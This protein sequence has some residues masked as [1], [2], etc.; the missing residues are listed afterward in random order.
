[1][2]SFFG[3]GG[4]IFTCRRYFRLCSEV[5]ILVNYCALLPKSPVPATLRGGGRDARQKRVDGFDNEAS[6]YLLILTLLIS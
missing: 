5:R 2:M 6:F 1:M 3:V 4:F